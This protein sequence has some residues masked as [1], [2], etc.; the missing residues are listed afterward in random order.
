MLTAAIDTA[1]GGCAQTAHTMHAM[2]GAHPTHGQFSIAAFKSNKASL[3]RPK[4]AELGH[5]AI[6]SI[7]VPSPSRLSRPRAPAPGR[8]C[9][10]ARRAGCW[11]HWTISPLTGR[12]AFATR[13][14]RRQRRG[15]G[16]WEGS[17]GGAAYPQPGR[18]GGGGVDVGWEGS[19]GGG[20][21]VMWGG[22]GRACK[23]MMRA[24]G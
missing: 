1:W 13:G 15:C 8:P 20:C 17:K 11:A 16:R 24:E 7:S 18:G 9:R 21:H 6:T 19:K 10:C 22:G 3:L 14:G 23:M 4:G 2:H 12:S 5:L